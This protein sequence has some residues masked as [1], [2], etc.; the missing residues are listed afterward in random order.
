MIR[1]NCITSFHYVFTGFEKRRTKKRLDKITIRTCIFLW[2]IYLPIGVVAYLS[3]GETSK[4]YDLF[5]N[6]TPLPGMNDIAMIVGKIAMIPTCWIVL[7]IN[8]Y[9]FKDQTFDLFRLEQN[10]KNNVIIT[11]VTLFGGTLI[12]WAY[13]HVIDW[14]SLL[15]AFCGAF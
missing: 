6:R 13:P 3:F 10:N 11:V 12:G 9:P 1:Y 15:G 5:P 8:M 2:A 4:Q 14:F 7:L